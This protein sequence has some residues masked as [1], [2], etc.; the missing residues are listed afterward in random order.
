MASN[1]HRFEFLG[2]PLTGEQRGIDALRSPH[3]R[4][5]DFLS[6]DLPMGS[7]HS[8]TLNISRTAFVKASQIYLGRTSSIDDQWIEVEGLKQLVE[9][10]KPE[11]EGS[12]VLVWV[13]FIGAAD[14]TDSGHRGFFVDRLD[15]VFSQTGFKNIVAGLQYLPAIWSL[16]GL[17]R[18]TRTLAQLAPSLVM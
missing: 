2:Q 8:H 13:C 6:C 14:S 3:E 1:N 12:H 15:R 4:G 11:Q 10:I 7:P 9:Q 5:L 16:Q 17:T 18:W